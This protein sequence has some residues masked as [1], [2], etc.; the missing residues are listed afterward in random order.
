MAPR[1]REGD[2]LAEMHTELC[3]TAVTLNP[4]DADA[5]QGFVDAARQLLDAVQDKHQRMAWAIQ[6]SVACTISLQLHGVP[7]EFDVRQLM[8]RE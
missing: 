3:R 5:R 7:G 1:L 2:I 6:L 8:E 4:S